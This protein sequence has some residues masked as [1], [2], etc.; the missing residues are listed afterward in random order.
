MYR[1]SVV[2]VAKLTAIAPVDATVVVV[3][4]DEVLVAPVDLESLLF[5]HD[6]R[7]PAVPNMN[8]IK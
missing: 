2:P 3:D 6:D 1:L 5:L 7:Q 8:N 4:V